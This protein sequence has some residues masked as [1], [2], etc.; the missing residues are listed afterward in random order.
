MET[1]DR[2]PPRSAWDY[3]KEEML[4]RGLDEDLATLGRSV[5]R[6]AENH[7]WGPRLQAFCSGGSLEEI[8][9]RAPG[10]A[11]R[12][13]TVLLETDG[14]RSAFEEGNGGGTI[15]LYGLGS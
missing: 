3:W 6:E 5:I 10:L 4:E 7:G 12:L 2:T 11:R 15:E 8:L 1:D 14:L 9:F 13:C